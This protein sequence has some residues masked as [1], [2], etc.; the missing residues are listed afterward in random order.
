LCTQFS[1][2]LEA[3]AAVEN[4]ITLLAVALVEC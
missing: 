3:A 1:L 4:F 2:S